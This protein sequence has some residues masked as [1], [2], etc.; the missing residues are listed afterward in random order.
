LSNGVFLDGVLVS[1]LPRRVEVVATDGRSL[2][3]AL[4]PR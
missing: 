4:G 1:E 3:E 2:V